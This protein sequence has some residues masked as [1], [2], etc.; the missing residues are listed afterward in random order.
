LS[1]SGWG[2]GGGVIKAKSHT[3]PLPPPDGDKNYN[4]LPLKTFRRS[5]TSEFRI[6]KNFSMRPLL[7]EEEDF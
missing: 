6:Q 4:L 3:L 5:F 2:A 1:P 7:L